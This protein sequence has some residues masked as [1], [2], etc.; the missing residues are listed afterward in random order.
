VLASASSGRL[1]VLRGAGLDPEVIVSGVD[2]DDVAGTPA[3]QVLELA[4]RK[5]TAVAASQQDALV[6]GCDSMLDV[7][8][9]ALG[10]PSGPDDA[11]ARW[12]SLR[13]RSATLLTG[14]CVIDTATGAAASDVGSTLVRFGT[15]SDSEISA[16]VATGEPLGV[17][18]AFT[19]DGRSSAFLDGIDGDAG[20]VIGI[21]VALLRTLLAEL[22][23]SL[24]D[25]WC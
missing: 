24:V 10:K 8:G 21:S 17:A 23:T 4:V 19:L 2:E 14:H 18:G 13:G 12:Q 11:V 7:D 22:D 5:A 16:Y 20:N 1:G 6:I 25:L 15:P 3:E 9:V